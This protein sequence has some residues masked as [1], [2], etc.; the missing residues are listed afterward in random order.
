MPLRCFL[1]TILLSL[2]SV[3][4][5]SDALAID[6]NIRARHL[7][8]GTILDPICLTP[9]SPQITNY[10]RCG[11]S[12]LWTGAYLAAESFRYNVTRSPDALIGVNAALAGLKALS[13]VTGNRLAR[14]LVLS[15]SPY[16]AAISGEET[17]NTIHQSPPW[18]WVDN[19]SRDQIIGAFF[20]LGVAFDLVDDPTVKSTAAD[21]ATRLLG[22]ISRH[23]W[24]PNDDPTST[25]VLRPEALQMLVQVARHLNPGNG[26]SGPFFVPPVETAVSVD[27]LSDDSYFKFNLDYLSFYGLLKLQDNQS[28]RNTYSIVRRHTAGHQNAFFNLIDRA[29]NGPDAARDTETRALLDQW[30]QRPRRDFGADLTNTVPVCGGQA[31]SPIPV[32]LRVPTD[33]LWQRSPFQLV[34]AGNGFIEA[35][36]IDYILPYWMDRY[37][38]LVESSRVQPAP[39]PGPAVAP[40]S[41]ASWFGNGLGTMVASAGGQPWPT[42]LGGVTLTLTDSTGALRPAGLIY[43]SPSQVNFVVPA[44]TALGTAH[45]TLANGFSTPS[46]TA[47][48]AAVAPGLFSMDG[49][50]SGVAA[51]TAIRT[52]AANPALQSPVPVF[53]CS[54]GVCQ[55]V[56][57]DLGIDT[58][59][60]VSFYGTG[61]R[62]RSN[63]TGVSVT[64]NGISVPVLYA[65]P[66]PDFDGLDQINVGLTLALRGMGESKVTAT[67][68]GTASNAVTINIK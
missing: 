19:T 33:F 66:S 30:L 57:I 28:N 22:Y 48:I 13:D 65:G 51:A 14:C 61:I 58:P 50:G 16:A 7:P 46:T 11:D 15:N 2:P 32:A 41:V 37:L 38:T 18:I 29:L 67:V 17:Q 39:A 49:T 12:A 64:I 9:S 25:F 42:S 26:I 63:L 55:S 6:A 35:A 59:V 45:L 5:E 4:A 56:P 36:G 8:F 27:V 47:T 34:A 3:A 10:T 40:G 53:Q 21:I 68:D 31:C 43:V 62:N 60:Y 54:A 44:A 24:S 52:M 23:N 1:V 20:G